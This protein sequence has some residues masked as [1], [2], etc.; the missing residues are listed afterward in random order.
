MLQ[1]NQINVPINKDEDAKKNERQREGTSMRLLMGQN[2]DKLQLP[3]PTTLS[4]S[5]SHVFSGPAAFIR[6]A[7]A[8]PSRCG[9]CEIWKEAALTLPKMC[10]WQP[11][12]LP[13]VQHDTL[14]QH[15]LVNN[16]HRQQQQRSS[17]IGGQV[18]C[19]CLLAKMK[20]AN[21][22]LISQIAR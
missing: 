20:P 12:M 22:L 5:F 8:A 21:L 15:N 1:D 17:N 3:L 18:I 16:K 13:A 9:R 19:G 10:E 4:D 14:L 6:L 7:P 2:K 11:R